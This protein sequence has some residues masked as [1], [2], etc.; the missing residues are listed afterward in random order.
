MASRS[1]MQTLGV[2]AVVAELGALQ[3]GNDAV[4]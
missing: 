1:H 4:G 3:S 2:A